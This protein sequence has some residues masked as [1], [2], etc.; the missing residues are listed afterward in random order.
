MSVDV[1]ATVGGVAVPVAEIDAREEQLR[2]SRLA[3]S[4]PRSG[5]SEG[6]QLRRW[7]TQLAVI[8]RVVAA[9]ASARGLTADG[10]PT[11]DELLPDLTVRMEIG[12]VAASVLADPVARAVFASVTADVDVTSEQVASYQ[13]RNPLR[14]SDSEAYEHLRAAARRRAFRLWLDARC[15]AVV[16]LAPG[17][18]HPGDPRQPDNTHRH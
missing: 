5:T 10:A 12:S 13:S 9:E 3:S 15:A 7:L 6:R 16:E 1:A 18:E 17:Y 2:A 11:E 4:L 14:Y 8:E